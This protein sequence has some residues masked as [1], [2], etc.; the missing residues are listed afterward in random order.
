M[1]DVTAG[2]RVRITIEG[3][4]QHAYQHGGFT[5]SDGTTVNYNTDRHAAVILS[6]GWETGDMIRTA[7][8]LLIRCDDGGYAHWRRYDPAN[9]E[10][11]RRIHDDEVNPDRV[12]VVQRASRPAPNGLMGAAVPAGGR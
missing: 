11:G 12:T 5:L 2:A 1:H 10:N 8:G 7:H 4:V 6:E 9:S 3:T